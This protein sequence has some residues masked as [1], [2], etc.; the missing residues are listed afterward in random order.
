MKVFYNK[1]SNEIAIIDESWY[2]KLP[3]DIHHNDWYNLDYVLASMIEAV[4]S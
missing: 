2:E 4:G 1:E 3:E